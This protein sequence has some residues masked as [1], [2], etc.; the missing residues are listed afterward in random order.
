M[1]VGIFANP[2]HCGCLVLTSRVRG[3]DSS[4]IE[5]LRGGNTVYT[6]IFISTYDELWQRL[7]SETGVLHLNV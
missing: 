6:H 2:P 3:A 4:P 1:V 7:I 5:L